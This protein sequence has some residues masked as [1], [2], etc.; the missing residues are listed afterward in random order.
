MLPQATLKFLKDIKKN[1]NKPWFDKHREQYDDTRKEF[2][3]FIQQ[4]I[5]AHGKHDANIRELTAKECVFRFN[6]D[7]R[8]SKDKSPYKTHYGAS[9]DK[10]GKKS[11]YA[12]YYI[13]IEPG[14]K[15]FVGGGL[16]MPMPSELKKVRQEIDYCHD[17]FLK[18]I[19]AKKF[20]SV[21]GNLYAGED[22]SLSKVPAGFEKDS[23]VAE[24]LKLK[25]W[26]ATMALTDAEV[27]SAQLK[28]KVL[29]AFDTLQPLLNFINRAFD[30]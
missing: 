28:K 5:D 10:G 7:I 6:R 9:I 8:F 24:Y 16:W 2:A 4:L 19:K 20:Q 15:S 13:H 21:F 25:S 29:T 27:T 30:E 1:N 18:I 11:I 26:L 22:I 12:G 3:I 23:P 17:E 14:G